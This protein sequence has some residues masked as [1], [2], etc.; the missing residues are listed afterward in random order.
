MLI[1]AGGILVSIVVLI[2]AGFILTVFGNWI[3][4]APKDETGYR[5]ANRSLPKS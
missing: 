4:N 2:F 5:T 3:F 1:L